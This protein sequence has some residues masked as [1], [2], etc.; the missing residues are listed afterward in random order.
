MNKNGE[1]LNILINYVDN[2][3]SLKV[4]IAI[5]TKTFV[6]IV[7]YI[8]YINNFRINRNLQARKK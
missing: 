8:I 6:L 3:N 2:I 4:I 7:Y 5:F 1:L